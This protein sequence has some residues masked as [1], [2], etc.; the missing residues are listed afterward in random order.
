MT[1]VL[2]YSGISN[3][4]IMIISNVIKLAPQPSREGNKMLKESL[5]KRRHLANEEF[6]WKI[7]HALSVRYAFFGAGA[8]RRSILFPSRRPPSLT[9]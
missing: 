9:K 8:W 3:I 1:A 4:K 2:Y 6:S 5:K 7:S